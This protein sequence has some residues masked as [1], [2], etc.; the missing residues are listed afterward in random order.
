MNHKNILAHINTL[1]E[2][3][4]HI[5][6]QGHTFWHCAMRDTETGKPFAYYQENRTMGMSTCSNCQ[7][8]MELRRKIR[9]LQKGI[10]VEQMPIRTNIKDEQ[11]VDIVTVQNIHNLNKISQWSTPQFSF[12]SCLPPLLPSP[13][14]RPILPTRGQCAQQPPKREH[15]ANTAPYHLPPFAPSTTPTHHGVEPRQNPALLANA[16]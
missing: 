10:G 7:K 1:L 15:L 2:F 8:L 4:Q 5:F 3:Q 16:L 14:S 11:F 9:K 6:A 12:S 13:R